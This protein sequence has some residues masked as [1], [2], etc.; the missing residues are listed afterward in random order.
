MEDIEAALQ[1]GVH[2]INIESL[3]E[4]R[5]VSEVAKKLGRKVDVGI[6][7]DP[8]L[9]KPYY[10]K[11]ITTYRKKSASAKSDSP[12]P[13]VSA[14]RAIASEPSCVPA[15]SNKTGTLRRPRRRSEGSPSTG[16][17]STYAYVIP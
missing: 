12:W 13:I 14:R 8:L 17:Y 9:S 2:M 16:V 7:I 5:M 4:A 11:V 15:R 6:R 1:W 3:T 10:D